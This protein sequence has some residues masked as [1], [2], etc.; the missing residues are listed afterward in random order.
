MAPTLATWLFGPRSLLRPL[1]L[2]MPAAV[3]LALLVPSVTSAR[4][5]SA[6]E[7]EGQG[8]VDAVR[9]GDQDCASVSRADFGAAGEY[10]M[11]QTFRS[12]RAHESMN[13]LMREMM[14]ERA[15]EQMHEYLGRRATRCGGGRRPA[16]FAGM[17]ATMS[18]MGG[19]TMGAS[20]AS[21]RGMMGGRGPTGGDHDDD[22]DGG[23]ALMVVLIGLLVVLAGAALL[24]FRPR[25]RPDDEG[26]LDVLARRYASGEI[27]ND[28]YE[29]RRQALGGTT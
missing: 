15:E 24:R 14:G 2:L 6:E 7:R 19:R 5:L 20:G 28:E 3:V 18:S 8:V 10:A 13:N 1:A 12:T 26:P 17:M 4:A 23:V 22:W 25:R 16:A 29:R 21:G 9:A 11:R 27:D